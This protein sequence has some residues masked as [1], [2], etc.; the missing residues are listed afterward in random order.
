[1]KVK[2]FE[3]DEVI[4]AES[5]EALAD[6]FVAHGHK[7]HSWE[8]PDEAVRNYACNYAEA[9][10]R[11]TG[12]TVRKEEIGEIT[13]SRVTEDSIDDWLQFFDHD[14]FA[15]NPDW[16]SCYCLEPHVPSTDENPERPWR[17]SRSIMVE[18]LSKGETYG[19]L[20]YVDSKP[21][22]WVNA[23]LRSDYEL[24]QQVD[25]DGPEPASVI[26]VSCFV[27]APPYRKH[28]VASALL[29]H[30]IEEAAIRGALWIE[31][32]PRNEPES[33]DAAH[34]RGPRSM[35][36]KRGF[37]AVVVRERDTVMRLQVHH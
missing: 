7:D 4:E 31:G 18:R 12:D 34:F 32:Y 5:L 10:E 29:D 28:G 33:N 11:L 25:S 19:Y 36:T 17:E 23:S 35:Y 16:A 13:I 14:G 22:G 30:V 15:G 21:V 2:C 1:M 37:Q 27:I 6:V 20:A 9:V 24:F 8:Y 3:C 26:G